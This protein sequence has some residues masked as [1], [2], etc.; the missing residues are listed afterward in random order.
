[1]AA[2]LPF[3]TFRFD[4]WSECEIIRNHG[5]MFLFKSMS[6]NWFEGDHPVTRWCVGR[7]VYDEGIGGRKVLNTQEIYMI[8]VLTTAKEPSEDDLRHMLRPREPGVRKKI[9]NPR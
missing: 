2:E 5:E 8:R 4:R 3:K 9:M 6:T 1:M 7:F